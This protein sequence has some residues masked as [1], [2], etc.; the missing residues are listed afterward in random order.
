M[1]TLQVIIGIAAPVITYFIGRYFKAE[2]VK[3]LRQIINDEALQNEVLVSSINNEHTTTVRAYQDQVIEWRDKYYK[4]ICDIDNLKTSLAQ[5]ESDRY[6]AECALDCVVQI[7]PNVNPHQAADKEYIAVYP[8][9]GIEPAHL[10][11]EEY[12]KGVDR[13]KAHPEDKAN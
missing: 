11:R 7:V 1:T 3:D 9:S 13:L 5:T 12:Q 6:H 2:K 4:A 8:N 10:T